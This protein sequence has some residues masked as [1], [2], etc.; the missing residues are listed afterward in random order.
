MTFRLVASLLVLALLALGSLA[1]HRPPSLRDSHVVIEASKIILDPKRETEVIKRLEAEVRGRE[2]EALTLYSE[3]KSLLLV[4][5]LAKVLAKNPGREVSTFIGKS[6]SS[7][8][9][10]TVIRG[11]EILRWQRAQTITSDQ[12]K[13][14]KFLVGN[15]NLAIS[16]RAFAIVAKQD[17]ADS[18]LLIERK[19]DEDLKAGNDSYLI[20]LGSNR[21]DRT[22]IPLIGKRLDHEDESVR[23]TCIQIMFM[24]DRQAATSYLRNYR[25]KSF[26]INQYIKHQSSGKGGP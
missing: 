8:N 25:D 13:T 4:P 14:A 15:E 7:K 5:T 18:R 22:L 23:M 11:L 20:A 1:C 10:E 3:T 21:G 26:N 2:S 12:Y 24:I 19:L 6:L 17:T 9:T 16:A